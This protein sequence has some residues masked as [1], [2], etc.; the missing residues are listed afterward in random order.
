MP[1][2][3][4]S[5]QPHDS[6]GPVLAAVVASCLA[7]IESIVARFL[8]DVQD[9]PGYPGSAVLDQDL[10]ETAIA[11]MELL[12]RLV[13]DLPVPGRLAGMPETLG[14]R[15]ATQGV[16]L[17]AL[18]KAVRMDFRILWT[19]MLER[20]PAESLSDFTRDA[21]RVWEA[22]EF[23]T[24]RVR[25]GYLEELASMADEEEQQRAFLLSRLLSSDGRDVQ[26]LT[27]AAR[28]LGVPVKGTFIVAV[29]ADGAGKEFRAAVTRA[30]AGHY[31]HERDGSL[32]LILLARP[33]RS[34]GVAA[35]I[36]GW[37]TQLRCFVAPPALGLA[38]VPKMVRIA[39]QA[40]AVVDFSLP[41]HQSIGQVWGAVSAERLGEFGEILERAV[42]GPLAEIPETEA[43]RLLETL[44]AYA[45]TGSVSLAARQLYCH[46]NTVLN[47]LARLQQLTGYDPTVHADAATLLAALNCR[48]RTKAME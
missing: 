19:E 36:P 5:L 40:V 39:L 47:R 25:A 44:A 15:R 22:V 4:W 11:S 28:A 24:T 30:H 33:S 27:Q 16:P 38:E 8:I 7:D 9:I 48:S 23:H 1:K 29:S 17:E 37:L 10:Q 32:M 35:P 18:L 26:L 41:G 6:A 13:G 3:D 21:V 14:R 42:L 43:D 46:R 31:L 2:G 45:K 34:E 20:V 12:L